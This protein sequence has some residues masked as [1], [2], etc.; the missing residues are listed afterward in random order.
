MFVNE[1]FYIYKLIPCCTPMPL[2]PILPMYV[3]IFMWVFIYFT[4]F[5]HMCTLFFSAL[6]VKFKCS[7]NVVTTKMYYSANNQW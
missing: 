7:K 3:Y 2:K 4:L 6:Q 5:M 1:L